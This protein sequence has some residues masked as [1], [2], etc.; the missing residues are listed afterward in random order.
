MFV[1]VLEEYNISR[2]FRRGTTTYACNCDVSLADIKA[3]NRWRDK[4]NA[5]GRSINQLMT[6]HYSEV[7]QLLP[8]IH[9]VLC[10]NSHHNR[11]PGTLRVRDL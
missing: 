2:S 9:L 1:D 6:D 5:Q 3:A 4:E 8:F 7:K 11:G 10:I